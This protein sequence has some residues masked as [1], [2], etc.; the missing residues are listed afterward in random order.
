MRLA[1]QSHHRQIEFSTKMAQI[2]TTDV[3]QLH[4]LEVLPDSLCRIQL[5]RI[6]RQLLKVNVS[7]SSISH[8]PGDL[9]TVDRRAVPHNQQLALP[10]ILDMLQE[11][12]TI[13]TRQRSL[14]SQRQEVAVHRNPAHH[15]QMS[16]A[17]ER[18][19]DRRLCSRRVG[20]DHSGQQVKAR[21]INKENGQAI[22]ARLFFNSGQTSM[23][24]QEM[25]FSSRRSSLSAGSCGVHFKALS[26]RETCALW[27]ETENSSRITSATRAHVQS[28]PRKPY[29]SAPCDRRSGMSLLCS[30]A[31]RATLC[32][33][34]LARQASRPSLCLAA[35][36]RLT[37][38]SETPK[39]WAMARPVHPCSWRSKARLRRASR[40]SLN[41]VLLRLMALLYR[42]AEL[43]FQMQRSVIKSNCF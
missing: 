25:A 2:F 34:V 33:R 12:H 30:S 31:N 1:S 18:F 41:F 11:A 19:D 26:K 22:F 4:M 28:W 17:Q 7:G 13:Q 24:Q 14:A 8:K 43:N 16:V 3:S 38:A 29:A 27:Y 32:P 20:S 5:R 15:R 6:G 42:A 40:Q 23:R 21:F 10:L 37:A 9:F 39:A 35:I 36:Q